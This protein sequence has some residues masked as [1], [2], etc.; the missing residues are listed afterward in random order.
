MK[1]LIRSK[2]K[3]IA[4]VCGGISQYINPELDPII[5]RV[6]W[7]ILTLFNPLMLL[8]YFILALV[9][10]DSSYKTA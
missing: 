6:A 2:E 4:G 3:K 5:I 7:L 9:L 10:P 8:V 1:R